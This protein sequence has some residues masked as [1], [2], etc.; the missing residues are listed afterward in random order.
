MQWL[1]QQE[2]RFYGVELYEQLANWIIYAGSPYRVEQLLRI[3]LHDLDDSDADV[4]L[5]S[6]VGLLYHCQTPSSVD[7]LL[8]R[9]AGIIRNMSALDLVRFALSTIRE[10]EFEPAASFMRKVEICDGL[11]LPHGLTTLDFFCRVCGG[12]VLSSV[13]F[14][15][16]RC[17]TSSELDLWTHIGVTAIKNG[18]DPVAGPDQVRSPLL[19]L[20][21]DFTSPDS[22]KLSIELILIA[23]GLWV[24]MLKEANVDLKV[25]CL[26]ESKALQDRFDLNF[27]SFARGFSNKLQVVAIE[28]DDQKQSCSLCFRTWTTVPLRSLHQPPGSFMDQSMLP[29]TIC[30]NPD[31]EE[32]EEGFWLIEY[33]HLVSEKISLQ[34]FVDASTTAYHGLVDSTQDDNGILTRILDNSCRSRR[35][36]KRSSSQPRPVRRRRHNYG[37]YYRS[38]CHLWLQPLHFCMDT[39]TWVSRDHKEIRNCVNGDPLE[40]ESELGPY[41]FLDEVHACQIGFEQVFGFGRGLHGFT[42]QCPRNCAKVNLDTLAVPRSLPHWHPGLLRDLFW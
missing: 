1:L 35:S 2:V 7:M 37:T 38:K 18:A 12:D 3:A 6:L 14:A 20:L 10:L 8:E 32:S 25:Y 22:D 29:T 30:W 16:G 41:G 11:G 42:Q 40:Y 36:R 34:E 23:L 19:D 31:Q 28:Y 17:V 21:S 39:S 4:N 9:C 24:D 15:F 13:A 27:L 26:K 33:V 5:R